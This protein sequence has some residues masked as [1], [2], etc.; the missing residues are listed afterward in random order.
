MIGRNVNRPRI[1]RFGRTNIHAIRGTPNRRWSAR[2]G[3]SSTFIAAAATVAGTAS[4]EWIV[5]VTIG[6]G[7]NARTLRYFAA[8]LTCSSM[9]ALIRFNASSSDISP[10]MA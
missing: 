4:N 10:T 8:A 3:G 6:G 9:S 5:K 2:I 1:A 7:A